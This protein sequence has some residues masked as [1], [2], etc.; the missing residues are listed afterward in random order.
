LCASHGPDQV[1]LVAN[2]ASACGLLASVGSDFHTPDESWL[3]LG[4]LAELPAG[5]E[6]VWRHPKLAGLGA[7]Q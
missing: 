6:P 4:Q 3:D 2:L 1:R 7:L 5:C